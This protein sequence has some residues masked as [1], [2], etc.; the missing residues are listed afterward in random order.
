M[1][2][3][4]KALLAAALKETVGEVVPQ[5]SMSDVE[6]DLWDIFE[7]RPVPLTEFIQSEQYLNLGEDFTLSDIQ[8]D[9]VR[10]MEQIF[11]QDTYTKMA[12][13]WGDYWKTERPVNNLVAAWGKGSAAPYERVY[14]AKTGLWKRLDEIESTSVAAITPG[15]SVREA[16]IAIDPFQEGFGKMFRVTTSLGR[17]IDVWEGHKFYTDHAIDSKHFSP[18]WVPLNQLQVGSKIAVAKKVPEP[19]DPVALP[20]EHVELIAFYLATTTPSDVDTGALVW[21]ADKPNSIARTVELFESFENTEVVRSEFIHKRKKMIKLYPKDTQTGNLSESILDFLSSYNLLDL[22]TRDKY[23]PEEIYQLSNEQL[24]LFVSRIFDARGWIH[25]KNKSQEIGFATFSERLAQDI[26]RIFLRLGVIAYL[27]CRGKYSMYYVRARKLSDVLVLG[28]QLS[29][30]DNQPALDAAIEH[31]RLREG[32]QLKAHRFGDIHWDTISSIEYLG[33]GEYWS[34]S[35]DRLS[36]YVAAGGIVNHNSGKNQTVV[37]AFARIAYLLLCLRDPQKYYRLASN[38]FIHMM[39]V[40]LSAPQAHRA[41]FKPMRELF[42]SA[43]WFKDKFAEDTPP[44]PQ[45]TTIR[46]KKRIEMI[47]GHSQAD[48]QEGNNLIAAVADEIAGFPINPTSGSE[49][50]PMKTADGILKMLKTSALTRF[51]Q[52][53]KLAQIS[54]ARY[55]GDPI[56]S[57]LKEADE[58][59]AENGDASTYYKSGPFST[60]EVNPNYRRNF[61]F[62]DIPQSESPVPNV[63]G[64]ISDYRKR[65]AFSRGYYECKPEA[66]ENAY[67]KDKAKVEESFNREVSVP[68]LTV[69]YYFGKDDTDP[70]EKYASW[71]VHF[72]FSDDLVPVPGAVYA[73]H[74]DMALKEDRAGIAMCHVERF[75]EIETSDVY[76]DE[77]IEYRPVVKMDFA[78]AFEY[79]ASAVDPD[80]NSVPRE[81]QMRWYRKLVHEL[82]RRGFEI[83]SVSQDGFGSLDSLQIMQTW[84]FNAHRLSAD[85]VTTQV[86]QTL[87]DLVYDGRFNGYKH[88]LL[89]REMLGVEKTKKGKVDHPAGESKDILDAVACSA[90]MAVECGGSEEVEDENIKDTGFFSTGNTVS[91]YGY[92]GATPN[93]NFSASDRFF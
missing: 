91:D 74:A 76:G 19:T 35:V 26:G 52:T 18:E 67:F 78:T 77:R 60:W 85:I 72:T 68:P 12:E 31:S 3:K 65:P 5:S 45:A 83:A 27:Q 47:S 75:K 30:L 90:T 82:S 41:F 61:E 2:A 25:G 48:S 10:H 28:R 24:R 7:E 4:T 62:V 93:N 37:I 64:I 54:F 51:P 32:N 87:R 44:G 69:S 23:V 50:A 55:Q 36:S 39:N 84:G 38:S 21:E 20:Q 1:D 71:Q 81:I 22:G 49:K 43:P 59:I 6:R 9:F 79:D 15:G 8:F 89:M 42:I 33:E 92:F 63:P 66:S 86:W 70:N 40:A 53:Y 11:F 56:M 13:A 17:H 80:G 88:N 73:I 34:M 16:N 46:L 29:L 14:D 58:D 57:A